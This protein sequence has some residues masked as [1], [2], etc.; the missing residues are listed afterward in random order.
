MSYV[1]GQRCLSWFCKQYRA[2][3]KW[4]AR[5]QKSENPKRSQKMTLAG[6]YQVTGDTRTTSDVIAYWT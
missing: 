3:E 6:M 1:L 4:E 2:R 5:G